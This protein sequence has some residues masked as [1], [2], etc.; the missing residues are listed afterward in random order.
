MRIALVSDLH[1][2]ARSPECVAHWHAARRAVQRIGV[3]LTV[4]LGEVTPGGPFCSDEVR[5][6]AQLVGQW[7]TDMRCLV[8]N[9]CGSS[10]AF[11]AGSPDHWLR[12]W[13]RACRP[14]LDTDH[15]LVKADGWRLLGVDA[16]I[17]GTGSEKEDSLW[18]LMDAETRASDAPAHTAVFLRWPNACGSVARCGTNKCEAAGRAYARL[19][20]GPLKASL[21]VV[22]SGHM[23]P[24][25]DIGATGVRHFLLPPSVRTPADPLQCRMGEKLVGVGLLELDQDEIGFELWCPDGIT[26]HP[27]SR[28]PIGRAAT[29][30]H[31]SRN[32]ARER[33][34][35]QAFSSGTLDR[36]GGPGSAC[37]RSTYAYEPALRRP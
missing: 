6:A 32:R 10:G 25:I 23:P 27:V 36:W 9:R 19:L 5:V 26:R 14:S 15:W 11:K 8:G 2:S 29:Q 34:M 7:P 4:H 37:A 16:Q 22:V 31:G 3:D 13:L 24:F 28:V 18:R 30:A 21:K 12:A 20:N 33:S 17:L 1:L 35:S